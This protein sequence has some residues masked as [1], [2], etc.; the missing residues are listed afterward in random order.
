MKRVKIPKFYYHITDKDFGDKV[1]LKPLKSDNDLTYNRDSSEPNTS[2]ICVGPDIASCLAAIPLSPYNTY[3]Y[4]VYKTNRKIRPFFPI[5]VK[6]SEI[7]GERWI[8]RQTIFVLK[9]KLPDHVLAAI[10]LG[11]LTYGFATEKC[12]FEIK[13]ILKRK[14]INNT[15]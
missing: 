9:I 6:D 15:P 11:D 13:K 14:G 4:R 7:S 3:T 12:L 10:A 5:G 2:R 1:L 8:R